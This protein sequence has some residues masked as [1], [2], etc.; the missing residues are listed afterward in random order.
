MSDAAISSAH[1]LIG[2]FRRADQS[3]PYLLFDM[4]AG[5]HSLLS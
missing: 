4:V 3:N 2:V 5:K 1:I